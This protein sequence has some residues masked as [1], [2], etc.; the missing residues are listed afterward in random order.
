MRPSFAVRFLARGLVIA[1]VALVPRPAAAQRL[2]VVAYG[3]A[4]GL[5]EQSVTAVLQ[6]RQGVLWVGTDAGVAR[7][8]GNRFEVFT[9][10]DGLVDNSVTAL[11][12]DASGRIPDASIREDVISQTMAE[13]ALQL[14]TLRVV[15]ESQSSGAP[16]AA[17]SIFKLVG[18]TLTRAGSQLKS[19]LRG[20][21]GLGWEGEAFSS[22]EI[23]ATRS[24]L[25]DRAITIYG[26]TNE[27]QM[28][29]IAKRVL[30]LPD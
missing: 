15:E 12:E 3:A 11:A 22:A 19:Q 30:G 26:G 25:R 4:E 28:N 5:P 6:D 9:E 8:D 17:T 20:T 27:V 2:H 18:S 10:A 23:D 1:A 24:W 13:K 7:Y 21:A 14:T 16:G 29:I